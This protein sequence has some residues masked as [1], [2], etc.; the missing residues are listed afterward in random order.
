[1]EAPEAGKEY[2]VITNVFVNGIFASTNFTPVT[3]QQAQF[4]GE[5]DI[6]PVSVSDGDVVVIN[7][8]VV[9]N[10][11]NV[12]PVCEDITVEA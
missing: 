8:M 9:D 11:E 7:V 5:Y 4:D 10:A 3:T 1:M 2:N 12:A 6:T